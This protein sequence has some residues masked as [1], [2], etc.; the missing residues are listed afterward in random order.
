MRRL[1]LS[2]LAATSVVA[3]AAPAAMAQSITFRI[4]PPPTWGPGVAINERE[5]NISQRIDAGVRDGSLTRDE[6]YRLRS[7]LNEI[8]RLEQRY[9]YGGISPSERNDLMNR[10]GALSQDVYRQRHDWE[11]R[12][13]GRG[14]FYLP[15][16][17]VWGANVAIDER[18][19]DISRRID[20]GVRDGSL[21]RDE[22]Y[23]LRSRLNDIQRLEA[24]YRR[25]G[26]SGYERTDLIN[27][28]KALSQDVYNQRHDWQTRRYR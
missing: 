26:I 10:L 12:Q 19:A 7:R 14:G 4:G 6:A 23:R 28:L 8:Q 2:A 11:M 17:P 16:P 27:R 9:R 15:P 24:R 5:A 18:E 3:F 1:L 25:G 13:R 20:N 21:T 22:A